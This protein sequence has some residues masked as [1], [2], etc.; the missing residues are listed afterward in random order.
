MPVTGTHATLRVGV[1]TAYAYH[2]IG[3]AV[4]AAH[5]GDTILVQ[6]GTYPDESATITHSISLIGTGATRPILTSTHQITNGKA[7]LVTQANITI[8]NLTFT[9]ATVT[10]HNGA[11]IRY[12]SG[13]LIVDH[14]SFLDNEEGILSAASPTGTI[15][16]TASDFE[17]NGYGDG[18]THGVY[19]GAIHLLSVSGSTFIGTKAGHHIKSRA[20]ITNVYNNRLDDGT[21]TTSYSVDLPNGGSGTIIGNTIIQ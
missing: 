21:G 7:Y 9:K 10:D 19:A 16:I 5:D 4:T 6:S 11:G 20:A 14:S 12:E 3:A 15:T 17:R 8:Q 18:Y 13:N 1:G 2:T